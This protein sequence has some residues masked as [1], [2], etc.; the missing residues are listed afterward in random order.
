LARGIEN[1]A[2]RVDSED[3]LSH[4]VAVGRRQSC[5]KPLEMGEGFAGVVLLRGQQ[6]EVGRVLP[7]CTVGVKGEG[8][9][10]VLRTE[11]PG[12][13]VVFAQ[14]PQN[15]NVVIGTAPPHNS[16]RRCRGPRRWRRYP[17]LARVR[18][19]SLLRQANRGRG[20]Y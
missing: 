9:V 12:A 19:S 15:L 10:A 8:L 13:C 3:A 18:T 4:V 1:S 14:G 5:Q 6:H 17:T 16:E 2:A 11:R 20:P 7:V